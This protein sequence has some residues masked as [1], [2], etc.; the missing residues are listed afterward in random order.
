M[1]G[2]FKSNIIPTTLI[3]PIAKS[4]L[5]TSLLLASRWKSEKLIASV[6]VDVLVAANSS[7]RY[8]LPTVQTL[9]LFAL[10]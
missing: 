6:E 8:L 5:P 7:C 9:E 1:T 3:V 10:F 4:T 2:I